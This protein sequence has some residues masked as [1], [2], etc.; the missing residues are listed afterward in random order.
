MGAIKPENCNYNFLYTLLEKADLGYS[1][2]GS[3][4]PHIYFKDYG[5][6]YHFVTRLKEQEQ[7]GNFFDNLDSLITLHQ[8]KFYSDLLIFDV[9]SLKHLPP[10]SLS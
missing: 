3:T 9:S 4:I 5:E 6:N 8:R 7:I 1:F 2:S 10:Y